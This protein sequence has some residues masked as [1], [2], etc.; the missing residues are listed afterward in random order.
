[1][2]LDSPTLDYYAPPT[3]TRSAWKRGVILGLFAIALIAAATMEIMGVAR[4]RKGSPANIALPLLRR[5][6]P[7]ALAAVLCLIPLVRRA[8]AALLDRLR[9]PSPGTRRLTT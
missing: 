8:V 1:M 3:S 9:E 2:N 4:T 6:G 7:F 5:W